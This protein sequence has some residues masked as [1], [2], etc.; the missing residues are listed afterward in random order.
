VLK[1]IS[2]NVKNE[3][4]TFRF[5]DEQGI[6]LLNDNIVADNRFSKTYDLSNLPKGIYEVELEDKISFRKY[7][8]IINSENLEILEDTTG[9]IYKPQ[10]LLEEHSISFNMLNLGKRDVTIVISNKFGEELFSERVKDTKAIHKSFDL[11]KLVDG[12]YTIEVTTKNK[13]FATQIDLQK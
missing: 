13:F 8:V 3:N 10:I 4:V 5:F 9:K 1:L 11:S 2:N 12:R 7:F 6:N